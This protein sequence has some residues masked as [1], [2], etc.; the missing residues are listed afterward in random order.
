MAP[1]RNQQVSIATEQYAEQKLNSE[2]RRRCFVERTSQELGAP[3]LD[4]QKQ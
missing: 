3:A 4:R 2:L 1:N